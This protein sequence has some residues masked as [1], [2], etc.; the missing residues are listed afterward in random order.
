MQR[1][2]DQELLDREK[3]YWDAI[4]DKD[5]E[6]AMELSD[7]SCIVVGAQGVGALDRDKLGQMLKEASYELTSYTF[8]DK[9]FQVQ[10]VADNVAIVAYNVR[11]DLVVDGK[12]LSL[13]AYDASVW[14]LRDGQ[15]RC[16]LHTESLKGDPFGRGGDFRTT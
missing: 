3:R 14:V 13:E 1:S 7:D 9:Q 11:E 4:Q 10:Q 5:T 16:A 12:A 15:W 2:I 6:T 8:D